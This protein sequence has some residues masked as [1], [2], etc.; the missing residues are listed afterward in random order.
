MN[1]RERI[2]A[3]LNLQPVDRTPI[4]FMRQAGRHLPEYRKI[5]SEHSFWDRCKNTELCAE[6]TLQ[7]IK[8]Y[9]KL[10]AAIVFSDILTPLPSLGYDVHYG[11]GIRIDQFKLD[12]VDEWPEFNAR[13]HAPWA[14]D[15]L[16][17]VGEKVGDSVA[18]LGFAGSPWTVCMYLISGGTGDKDFHNARAK[19]FSN[20]QK[21]K[22]MLIKMGEIVGDLMADQVV[23][24][25]ADAVQFFDT[26]AGLLPSDLYE[27]FA[28]PATQRAIEVFKEKAGGNTPII[29]YAKGS[30]HLHDSIRK[31]DINAISLD[32]RDD[33]AYNR[34]KYGKDF[35]FQ[36]NLDPSH[37]HGST[38][39]ARN[40]TEKVMRAAGRSPGHIFNLG[41]GFAPS[42]RIECVEEV[43][44]V[45]TGA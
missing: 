21:S 28:M 31:L 35:A 10:D 42:A 23:Y 22:K 17:S 20:P 12:D 13:K 37:L 5:A 27:K 33:L 40:A 34:S 1:G 9:Q 19:V 30:G 24:G 15:G 45:V 41:H 39:A 36:G 16:K 14:A 7:P 8:R 11:N 6:I 3:A 25:G 4:W 43:I 32:W 44:R 38:E 2:T 29:H 26:W 18:K